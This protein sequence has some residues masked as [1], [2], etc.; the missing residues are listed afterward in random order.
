[1]VFRSS[2]V[3]FAMYVSTQ[4]CASK[5]F[6]LCDIN[7]LAIIERTFAVLL[8]IFANTKYFLLRWKT[9]HTITTWK[10]YEWKTKE[11]TKIKRRTYAGISETI[12]ANRLGER[13]NGRKRSKNWES[14]NRLNEFNEVEI[15]VASFRCLCMFVVWKLNVRSVSS[16]FLRR[17]DRRNYVRLYFC[18]EQMNRIRTHWIANEKKAQ[19]MLFRIPFVAFARNKMQMTWIKII[20][21][22][23]TLNT[24][25]RA[26]AEA[27]KKMEKFE[28]NKSVDEK[29]E[30]E[31]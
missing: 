11:E 26:R 17:K 12:L 9:K 29:L 20:I 23:W 1:M 24:G 13:A 27:K 28:S 8:F 19:F 15:V 22:L 25:R 7:M 30:I 5:L 14:W 6:A 3:A 16:I 21:K 18:K 2:I 10:K 31:N 4:R